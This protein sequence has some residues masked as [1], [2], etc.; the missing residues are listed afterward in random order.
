MIKKEILS[1]NFQSNV[2][3]DILNGMI[4]N[5]TNSYRTTVNVTLDKKE[6][7]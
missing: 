3:S 7:Y 2:V 5:L 4:E 1:K 6:K